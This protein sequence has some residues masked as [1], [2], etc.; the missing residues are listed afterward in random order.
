M[1]DTF[2]N[3]LEISGTL[4]TITALRI[5]AG[6]SL[7]PTSSDLPVMKDALGR[8]L[9]P[10]SSFKGAM[11]S[12]LESFLRGIDL[13]LA[14]DPNELVDSHWM[15]RV[16]ELKKTTTD[17]ASLTQALIAITDRVSLLFGSPWMA[18]KLQIQDLHVV[19]DLWFGQYQERDGVSIDRDTETAAD[20]RKY[21]FQVVPAGTL[22]SF[23]AI[24]ENATD[25]ELG[26]LTIGLTQ[27]E[28]EMIPLGG[29]NSRGLG[30][31]KLDLDE[32]IWVNPT[33]PSQIIDYLQHSV[34]GQ[35]QDY[36]KT[37]QEAQSLKSQW[38][39]ALINELR[40]IVTEK[41]PQPILGGE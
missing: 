26:L 14:N 8:P 30:V 38:S 7:D 15:N 6:R 22:F 16:K 21:D 32:M 25:A 5:G 40:S 13:T 41:Q 4:S 20:G 23:K 10:G 24:V 28:D 31:V 17:D 18:G 1:F 36:V 12:R 34:A 19:T 39:L 3:R 35:L 9:I 11:R 27:F 37:G 2:K 33:S 29:G